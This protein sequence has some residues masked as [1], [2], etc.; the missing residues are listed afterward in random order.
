MV[1]EVVH[2]LLGHHQH[3][4]QKFLHLGVPDLSIGEYLPVE[5]YGSLDLKVVSWLLPLDDQGG[6]YNM[7]AGR[8][9]EEKGFSSF[10]CDKDRGRR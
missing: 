10:R 6:A 4:V 3:S 1:G 5:V 8:D 2:E 7:V 9:I